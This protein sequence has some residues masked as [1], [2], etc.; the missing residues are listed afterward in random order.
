MAV[1]LFPLSSGKTFTQPR[2]RLSVFDL[3]EPYVDKLRH[4]MT[5]IAYFGI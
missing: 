4:A 5:G 3:R 1:L 2:R